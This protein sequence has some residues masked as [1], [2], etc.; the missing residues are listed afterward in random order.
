MTKDILLDS[1]EVYEWLTNADSIKRYGFNQYTI[2]SMFI[3]NTYY[4]NFDIS[5]SELMQRMG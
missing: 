5:V 1:A 4:V 3:P 2:V